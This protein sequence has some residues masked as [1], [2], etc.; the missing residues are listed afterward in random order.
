MPELGSQVLEV[1]IGLAFVYLVFSLVCSAAQE[2]LAT[3][4]SWRARNLEEALRGMLQGAE[5]PAKEDPLLDG[6]AGHPRIK[7]MLSPKRLIGKETK[8][9]D[10]LSARS[11]SAVLLDTIAPPVQGQSEDVF[12]RLQT[13]IEDVPHESLKQDLRAMIEAAGDKRD[14][15]RTEIENWFD[16]TMNRA[17]GWY[18]R[19]AQ[20]WLVV[21]AVLVAAI[22]N[23]DT[24]HVVDRLW[25]DPGARAAIVAQAEGAVAAGETE[26]LEQQIADDLAALELPV[27]WTAEGE[28]AFPD[29]IDL[30]KV[31]GILISA[32]ALS[33]GAPFWFDALSKVSR[34]RPTGKPEGREPGTAN[35]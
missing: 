6:I 8:L 12:Q 20:L 34:L 28:R 5:R 1:V 3:L 11:F 33:L 21:F 19:K 29:S 17:S 2:S 16:D 10:Y 32:F 15:L 25:N 4:L 9:P 27:G 31:L 26:G 24:I 22:G 14:Q 18:R 7:A 13:K 35:P 30:E 23:V